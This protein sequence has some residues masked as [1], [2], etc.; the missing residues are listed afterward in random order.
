M[1]TPE[2]ILAPWLNKELHGVDRGIKN[3]ETRS[4]QPLSD[5]LIQLLYA[6]RQLGF[7]V[8][9]YENA[10]ERFKYHHIDKKW[11][12]HAAK[13]RSELNQLISEYEIAHQYV[14]KKINEYS[15]FHRSTEVIVAFG[16]N[17]YTRNYAKKVRYGGYH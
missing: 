9:K 2:E 13:V 7:R 3:K 8:A 15:K 17:L 12:K 1:R 6:L 4:S 5:E 11:I 10:L 16:A 14:W